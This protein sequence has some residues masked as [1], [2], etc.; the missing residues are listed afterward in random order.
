MEVFMTGFRHFAAVTASGILLAVGAGCASQPDSV[1]PT[2][3]KEVE[4]NRNLSFE[5]PSNGRVTVFDSDS[6]H[7]A[8]SADIMKGNAV[9]VD[10]DNNRI[11]LNGQTAVENSLH[12]GDNYRIFFDPSSV[13]D[14]TSRVQTDTVET[15]HDK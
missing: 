8:Y 5:A 9:M 10:N 13:T 7:I 6:Q 2:A 4:G 15:S 1:S 11:T 14:R 3:V 12:K